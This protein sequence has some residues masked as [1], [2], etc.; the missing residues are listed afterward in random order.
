MWFWI[1][2]GTILVW[3]KDLY[4]LVVDSWLWIIVFISFLILCDIASTLK[5]IRN[6][7]PNVNEMS[8]ISEKLSDIR[9]ILCKQFDI[10]EDDIPFL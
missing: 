4:T 8:E 6:N 7:I 2:V 10:D 5:S 9:K 3:L 1:I